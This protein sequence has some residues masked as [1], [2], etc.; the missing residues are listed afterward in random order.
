MVRDRPLR[1]VAELIGI[2]AIRV[3]VEPIIVEYW[4]NV[5]MGVCAREQM[6]YKGD[7]YAA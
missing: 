6:G 3:F 2:G 1:W 4:P 5:M 7:V